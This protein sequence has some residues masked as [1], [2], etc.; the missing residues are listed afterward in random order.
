M[1]EVEREINRFAIYLRNHKSEIITPF[2]DAQGLLRRA[3]EKDPRLLV[4]IE[5]VEYESHLSESIVRIKYR[6]TD[7]RIEDIEKLHSEAAF[8]EAMHREI[9]TV[10]RQKIVVIPSTLSISDCCSHF[11]TKY[12]GYYSNLVGIEYSSRRFSSVSSWSYAI[13]QLQYRIG[14]VKLEMME[15]AVA[16][17]IEELSLSLFLPE[18]TPEVRAYIAHNYLARTVTYWKKAEPNPLERSYMQSAYGA[19]INGK[20]VCQGYAE[21]YKRLLDPQGIVCEV[22]CGKIRGSSVYH[23][24][25]IVSFDG[26][27]EFFHVDVTWDSGGDGNKRDAYFCVPDAKLTTDRIWTRGPGM[28]CISSRNILQE[29]KLQVAENESV[30]LRKGIDKQ[31][32]E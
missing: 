20:C 21:A 31:Y 11:I 26:G 3:L 16:Q 32:L 24:W 17:K 1:I 12:R 2:H 7:V 10:T 13:L 9:R 30:F 14:R 5:R 19:L 6:N 22:I 15:R 29:V 25:N 4:Y 8:E 23:A 27:H 28:V 18:M